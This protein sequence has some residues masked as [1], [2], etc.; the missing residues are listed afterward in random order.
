MENRQNLPVAVIGAG[1]IGL[2]AAAHLASRG[3]S[4]VVLEA[5]GAVG[6]AVRAW[7]HVQVFS[8]W[9]YNV[10]PVARKLLAAAGWVE[11]DPD[12]LPTGRELVEDYLAPLAALP[13][14]APHIRL[15]TR[16][17]AISRAG[18]DK[19]VT[20]GREAAPFELCVRT[21]DVDET[22]LA[23][24]VI[25]ASGTWGSP[26]PLGASGLPAL[27]EAA[28][29]ERIAY[30]IPDV[31]GADRAR[32]A[33]RRLLVVG[34]GH[35]AFNVLLDLVALAERTATS[36][37]WVI[38]RREIGPL[39]GGGAAD[40]LPAR[41]ALG[42]RLQQ[43]VQAGRVRLVTGFRIMRVT[44]EPE[45]VG[46]VAT[47]GRALGPFDEIVGATGFRPDLGMLGELRLRLDATVESPAALATL[48]DPNVHSCGT[49]PPH[50]AEE[51]RHPEPD[52][53]VVGMKSYGRAPTFL[54]LTGYEQV[55][56]V[57]AALTGDLEAARRVELTLPETGVCSASP[58]ETDSA[59][60]S[61]TSAAAEA[62]A[63]CEESL[64]APTGSACC[65]P[66]PA[67]TVGACC[68]TTPAVVAAL[69]RPA[70]RA[71]EATASRCRTAPWTSSSPIA[72]ST[73]DRR[74]VHERLHPGAQAATVT[75][76]RV[77]ILCTHNAARSQMAE[78]L[79][80]ALAGDR[81]EVAS[82]G[83][84]ATGVHPL[85]IRAMDEVGIDLSRHASKTLDRFL[86][87]RWDYV[88]TVCDRAAER[89]PVFS[90]PARRVHWSLEDPSAAPGS[91]ADRLVVFR[92]VR[93]QI[94]ERLRGW[95]AAER[96]AV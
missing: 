67:E 92:R 70:S 38:R 80:R 41:G 24:A 5:G 28:A 19:L 22:I 94:A 53:Y 76:R 71:A 88:M 25:D 21:G 13:A 62:G 36:I 8:P 72:S 40:A 4:F 84:E 2:A 33:G 85:A 27:G 34:S 90:G 83:T 46:V 89:C 1:P 48:I 74:Q 59:C 18:V 81:F 15:A 6:A 58:A 20:A 44:A 39:Y 12:H 69:G 37:T 32:Y 66:A 43:A 96:I 42:T 91:D 79:L 47:D 73:Y 29:R 26:N 35:S 51:L 95:L 78:A 23:R 93:D 87:E 9:R 16:V 65:A 57:V 55:R 64:Q 31:L 45:G 52:F 54:M 86:D 30:G 14:L 56:S 60:C 63:C 11:P 49:V 17:V 82:A 68:A 10:D 7:S 77:L 61:A 3:E 75:P 50:G